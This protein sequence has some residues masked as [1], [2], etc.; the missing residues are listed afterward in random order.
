MAEEKPETPF[1]DTPAGKNLNLAANVI[2]AGF[3]ITGFIAGAITVYATMVKKGADLNI[4]AQSGRISLPPGL[5]WEDVS[6]ASGEP[7]EGYIE[8]SIQNI[9]DALADRP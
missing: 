8:L 6:A 5:K 1:A 9:G 7:L 4:E 2:R 3:G